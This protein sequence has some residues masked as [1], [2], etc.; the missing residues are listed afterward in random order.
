MTARFIETTAALQVRAILQ[1]AIEDEYP[2]L[3]MSDPGM[4]K[5]FSLK[6]Y[7]SDL[8]GIYWE[9]R[10]T[11]NTVRQ[12]FLSLMNAFGFW[13]DS[14]H[15]NDIADALYSQLGRQEWPFLVVDEFQNL[16]LTALRELLRIAERAKIPLVLS[17]NDKR[18]AKIKSYDTALDQIKSRIGAR[19]TLRSPFP[20]DCRNIAVEF[21]VEGK[22]AYS[23]LETFGGKT[24][25]RDLDI[26]LRASVRATQGAGSVQLR[27]IEQACLTL[28]DGD[29]K[30][31]KLLRTG[32]LA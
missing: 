7:S 2:A 17:G 21:N 14:R 3:V 6:H 8:K 31:L 18:L 11:E 15:T 1:E 5:T 26:L 20:A 32:E 12:M 16:D 22:D 13:H 28:H 9:V 29:R 24:S 19:V 27:H 23:A 25:L 4:G 10:E 30:A